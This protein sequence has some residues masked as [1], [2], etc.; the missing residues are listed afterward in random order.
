[1]RIPPENL[2]LWQFGAFWLILAA[3]FVVLERSA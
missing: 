1:M 2:W 3:L